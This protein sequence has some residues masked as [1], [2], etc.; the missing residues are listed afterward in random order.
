MI[1]FYH[2]HNILYT[3]KM[4]FMIS[5]IIKEKKSYFCIFYYNNKGLT[6]TLKKN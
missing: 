6:L 1:Q 4:Y 5:F 2:Y 3:I